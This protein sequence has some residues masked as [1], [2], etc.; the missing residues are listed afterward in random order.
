[1]ANR[2]MTMRKIRETLRLRHEARMSVRQIST[3]TDTSV[4]AIQNLL[5]K[6]ARAGVG[7][8]LPEE[9]ADEA[10]VK[11]LYPS[12]SGA[13]R[14]EFQLPEWSTVHQEL[15]RKDMTLQLLW[16]EYIAQHP[17]RC[18][19]Y[20]QFC[21]LFVSWRARQKRSMRQTHRFGEKSF[22]DYCGCTVPVHDAE[23]GKVRQAQ[24]FVGVLG[25]SNYTYA[26]ASWGQTLQ[27]W[28]ASHTRMVNFFGGCSEMIVP[29]NLKSAVHK[30]CR[31]DPDV[32]PSYQQ[33]AEHYGVAVVP[34]RPRRPK[35]KSKVEVS[36]QIV[37]RW[38]LARLRHQRFF[39][40][41]QL[42]ERIREL[43]DDLNQRPFKQMPGNRLDT[44]TRLEQPALRALP[45][46]AYQY[47]DIKRAK[48]GIDY[49]VHYACHYYSVPHQLWAC[50]LKCT[51]ATAWCGCF[52][53]ATRLRRIG[54][55]AVTDLPPRLH[56]CRGATPSTANGIRH[57]SRAGRG[58]KG[59][60][61]SCGSAL[62]WSAKRILNRPIECV[63][64]Y[65]I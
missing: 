60:K 21:A 9:L 42:N 24:V 56:T 35:D 40:L 1:M 37:E 25:A 18:Y 8:P 28:L 57:G 20:S 65:S 33:W 29:D 19:S 30:A 7:W 38:I 11:L 41:A 43:L 48:V 53:R 4:G 31:Y 12:R 17:G 23:H 6:A 47:V 45:R 63:S 49:H 55:N 62:S 32:N 36:V 26:E 15:K 27:E 2:R 10:L 46:H 61:F 22:V 34:A 54:E 64:G 3:H 14:G 51:A 59:R 16:E 13:G 52:T 39:S 5:N 50:M 58:G 44:F